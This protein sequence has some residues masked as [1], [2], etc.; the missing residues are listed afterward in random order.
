MR[1]AVLRILIV[2]TYHNLR[3][4][5]SLAVSE[6]DVIFEQDSGKIKLEDDFSDLD[7]FMNN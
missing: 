5:N 6:S 4:L 2:A 7:D 1:K 3:P